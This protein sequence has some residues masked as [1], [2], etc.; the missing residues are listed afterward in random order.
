MTNTFALASKKIAHFFRVMTDWT[1][2]V[3]EVTPLGAGCEVGRSCVLVTFQDKKILFDCGIHPAHTGVTALPIFDSLDLSEVDV[4]LVTHFHLDHCGALPYLLNHTWFKGRVL[5]TEPTKALSLLVWN[6]YAAFARH[7]TS[8][9]TGWLYH[10]SDVQACLNKIDTIHFGQCIE[11]NGIEIFCFGAGHVVGACM[12]AIKVG[13]VTVLYTG[14]YSAEEDRHVP[15]ASIPKGF[16][17]Q[18]L[19]SESTYGIKLHEERNAREK[20]F[21]DSIEEI[22]IFRKGKCLLPIFALGRVQELLIILN[23]HWARKSQ[24]LGLKIP[25]IYLSSLS[26]K[27]MDVMKD[28]AATYGGEYVK[29]K[30]LRGQNAFSFKYIRSARRTE[31]IM[32]VLTKDGPCVILAAP[33]MLQSGASREIFEMWA[34]DRRNGVILTGYTLRGTLADQLKGVPATI[35]RMD[36]REIPLKL[37]LETISFSAHADFRQ[38]SELIDSILPPSVILVHGEKNEMRSLR[39]KLK[40]MRPSL[41]VFTPDLLQKVSLKFPAPDQLIVVGSA[42]KELA[43]LDNARRAVLVANPNQRFTVMDPADFQAAVR[44]VVYISMSLPFFGSLEDLEQL[45][46]SCSRSKVAIAVQESLL[47]SSPKVEHQGI[48]IDFFGSLVTVNYRV[49]FSLFFQL[50]FALPVLETSGTS[51][52]PDFH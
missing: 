29:N 10:Q 28:Y 14:D 17:V 15:R 32:D 18:V 27:G 45:S 3:L 26:D 2:S 23:E 44:D 50:F 51:R 42:A 19:I 39:D 8:K 34:S 16:P 24:T 36:G 49:N 40:A 52:K 30:A 48:K 12:F 11:L 20:R 22:V 7:Y 37:T 9:S 47:G 46:N 41:A 38:T 43:F 21:L 1:S 6:D 4:C 31:D 33:G 25:V 13:G 5:M 35:T